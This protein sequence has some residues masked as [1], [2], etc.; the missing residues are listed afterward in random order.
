SVLLPLVIFLSSWVI[1]IP[2]MRSHFSLTISSS[3]N[4]G[5]KG[6]IP[7]FSSSGAANFEQMHFLEI[8]SVSSLFIFYKI[9]NA[10]EEVL[11]YL[12]ASF[13]NPKKLKKILLPLAPPSSPI[14]A[15][16]KFSESS[17]VDTTRRGLSGTVQIKSASN[18]VQGVANVMV[19]L[20]RDGI[21]LSSTKTNNKGSFFIEL[22]IP[23]GGYILNVA[24]KDYSGRLH[25]NINC[26]HVK[27]LII[28]SKRLMFVEG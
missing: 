11:L 14:L 6:I 24:S 25:I 18:S 9:K 5:P 27:D 12:P 1:C 22:Q 10:R 17:L 19:E 20:L 21:R 28:E 26:T 4:R 13:D 3:G 16:I 23:T 15:L 2:L 7:Y 8:E